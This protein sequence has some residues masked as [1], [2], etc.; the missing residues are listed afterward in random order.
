ML[1]IKTGVPMVTVRLSKVG[2]GG[3]GSDVSEGSDGRGEK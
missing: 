1:I 2:F 3:K